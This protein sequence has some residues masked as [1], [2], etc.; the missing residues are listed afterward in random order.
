MNQSDTYLNLCTQ[1]YELSKPS[2]PKDAYNFYKS[3]V[4]NAHGSVLEPMCGTGRFLLP[5]LVDGFEIDGFDAS[6]HMLN[7]LHKKARLQSLT[8]NVWQGRVEQ[9]STEKT[10]N[11]IFIPSGSFGLLIDETIVENTL[12]TFHNILDDRGTLVFEAETLRATPKQF[13]IPRSSAYQCDNGNM[14]V[15]T[16]FDLP[17]TNNTMTSICRYELVQDNQI[18]TTEIEEFKVKLY[19]PKSLTLKLKDAGFSKV[20]LH[21][22]FDPKMSPGD[23]EVV[24]YECMK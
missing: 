7:I 8:P 19:D 5:L 4:L 23:D 2:A 22:A 10:Y 14:I 9:M 24:V 1:V 21:K 20:T 6:P 3:Y 11:L 18:T 15:A 12:K 17:P 13:G 16:F